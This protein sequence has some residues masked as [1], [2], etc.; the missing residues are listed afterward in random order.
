MRRSQRYAQEPGFSLKEARAERGKWIL[1]G[2]REASAVLRF[3]KTIPRQ[4]LKEY[5]NETSP[6]SYYP[7]MTFI[8]TIR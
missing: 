7:K 8:T 4:L 3:I 2:D 6:E 1:L 5:G